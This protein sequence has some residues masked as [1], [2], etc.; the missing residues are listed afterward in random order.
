MD[1]ATLREDM[2]EGLEHVLDRSLGTAVVS[3][4][5]TVPR[6]AFVETAPYQNRSDVIEG[7]R[8]LPPATVA[9]LIDALGVDSD[10][11][12][13]IVGVGVGYTAAVIAEIAGQRNVHA[14]DIDRVLVSRARENLER[15]GYGGV[16]V[17]RADGDR[18]YPTYAPYDRILLEAAVVEPPRALL[19]QT[20]ADGRIALPLGRTEQEIVAIEPTDSDYEIVDRAG[21]AQFRPMLVDGEQANGPIRNRTRRE[22]AEF[23]RQGYFAKPGWEQEW[24]D[25]EET[26]R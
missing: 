20:A 15:A 21:G 12:V 13:L 18:G 11:S 19:E 10:D 22:D 3:A 23:A 24:I 9:R 7:T 16:L 2:V 26:L 17:D 6:E 5:R 4:L 8:V 1:E 25:W 14:I